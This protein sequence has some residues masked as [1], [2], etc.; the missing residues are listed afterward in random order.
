[1]PLV[2]NSIRVVWNENR[3]V[4]PLGVKSTSLRRGDTAPALLAYLYAPDGTPANLL[5]STVSLVMRERRSRKERVNAAAVVEDAVEGLVR[6]A[7]QA[8]DTSKA[9]EFEAWFVVTYPSG[10]QE[11]FPNVGAHTVRV[12]P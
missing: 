8:G 4:L 10:V 1:M 7:W 3:M 2:P 12:M 9:G 11:S 5:G 6:Y